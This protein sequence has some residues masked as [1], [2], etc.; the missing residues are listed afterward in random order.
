MVSEVTR[1]AVPDGA[2]EV[3]ILAA[4]EAGTILRAKLDQPRDIRYKGEI[5]LV[6]DADR[7]AE[8]VIVG[9]VRAAFPAHRL[10][11]EEGSRGDPGAADS[12]FGWVIDPLDGTTNYAHR[13]PHFA[14]SIGLER[15][16]MP[17][18]GVVYDPMRD[19][20]F[21]GEA[22]TG[23]TLNGAPIRVSAE[24]DLSRAL[25]ATG[26]AYDPAQRAAA[27]A[28]WADLL[29]QAQGVRRDGSAALDL[30]WVAAG[31]LDGFYERPLQPW[32]MGAGA[33]IVT[34]AGGT[35]GRFDG[36]EFDPYGGE[37]IATNGQIHAALAAIVVR[38][39]QGPAG[40][41]D[42]GQAGTLERIV[43]PVAS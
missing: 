43:G 41:E 16:G 27:E 17:V 35:I 22:G 2:R 26:F 5:D 25:L 3:A 39:G 37:I 6:T 10:I 36:T 8:A 28:I 23:S 1:S 4:R 12:P 11:G 19:E 18:L 38:H 30:C 42:I 31:R 7:A 40:S 9:R 34:G 21:V 20:L 32:D 24:A 33:V 29:F 15:A 13:Y 14:V